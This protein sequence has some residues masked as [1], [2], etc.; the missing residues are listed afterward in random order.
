M[1]ERRVRIVESPAIEERLRAAREFVE[2][3][4]PAAEVLIVGATREAADD[5]AREIAAQG[6]GAT[7]GMHRMSLVQLAVRC[8]TPELAR[9]RRAPITTLGLEALTARVTFEARDAGALPYFGAVARF[10]GFAPALAA[11]VT[12]LRCAA[13]GADR[14]AQ[15][16]SAAARDVADLLR[17]FEAHLEAAGLADRAALFDLGSGAAES[18]EV[19]PLRRLPIVLLDV[20]VEAHVERRFVA[21]LTAISPAVLITVA[22]GDEATR[23]SIAAIFGDPPGDA[24]AHA[25]SETGER[26]AAGDRSGAASD[27]GRRA[28]GDTGLA[29]VRAHLFA[30]VAPPAARA[31]DDV[32]FF[33]APGEG[34]EV[35]EIARLVLDRAREGIPFDRMAILLRAP[36]A[37]ASLLEAALARGGIP[38]FFARGTRRPDPAGRAF[39]ALLQCAGERFSARRFAEY[40][41]LGQVPPLDPGGAP[42]A[43]APAWAVADDEVLGDAQIGPDDLA[44]GAGDDRPDS[45]EAPVVEGTLRAPWKWEAM[46]VESA[47]IGGRDRWARRLAGLAA[48]Y[49]VRVEAARRDDP[50]SPRIQA[51]ERDLANLEHLRRFA[52][53]IVEALAALPASATWGEW[54]PPL[55]RLAPLVLRR[56]E[57]VLTVL[58]ELR[59]LGPVGPVSL[60]EVRDV[61][62]DRLA[63]LDQRPP[64]ARYGSVFVGG[65]EQARGR[66]FDVVFVP[67]L[68]ERI[69]PQK[70]REDPILLDAL[71]ARIGAGLAQQHERGRRE[72]W[73]LRLAASAASRRLYLSYARIDVA[74]GRAR[75]PS[76]YALE[77]QRALTG[78][79][80]PP[81]ALEEAAAAAAGARLAWPAPRDPA[82][83][84]D[85]EEHDL[86]VLDDAL[87]AAA[88][89]AAGRARYL[90]QL[91]PCLARS[92]RARWARW[93]SPKWTPQDGLV[94][95]TE[96]TR[97][98]FAASS[99]RA[100]PYS[101]SALQKFA[102]CP[103]QFYLSAICRLEPREEIAPLDRLDPATRGQ[104]FHRVQAEAMRALVSA[105]LLPLTAEREPRARHIL[106]ETFGRVAEAMREE[107]APAIARV[108]Q[109][110]ID[111]MR[112]DLRVWLERSVLIHQD[113]EP[114]AFELAF[115]LAPQPE[116][117]PRSVTAEAAVGDFRLRGIVDLIERRRETPGA[118]RADGR[119]PG[120]DLRVTDYKTGGNYT[121]WRMVVGGGETLQPVLY[122]LAV[123]AVLGARVVEGRLFYCTRE[124]A[125]GE[126]VVRMDEGARDTGLQVL[127]SVD[128]ALA[129]GFL[130]AAPRPRA[131]RR[132]GACEFCDFR[133][134]CGPD[135]ERRSQ[136]KDRLALAALRWLRDLP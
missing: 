136:R 83:A 17:R 65:I 33:A 75:V 119:S 98:V 69:F 28:A 82:R 115:G 109:T 11:T 31:P 62:L 135:E 26:R 77:V 3:L 118:Q 86:A 32:V 4:G 24:A 78:A 37:Y 127:S 8:A 48:N 97:D 108:W 90:L 35:V 53:P 74:V 66:R 124:G 10:P 20:P 6:G 129:R 13:I 51:L 60:D 134:V 111:S 88:G 122:P 113:W 49:R 42:I 29:R 91:N 105:G 114:V 92:L 15:A 57:R 56:H 84:V 52:L 5:I 70:P 110:E 85:A 93:R 41:S 87:R 36:A 100:R 89:Q 47:V 67:G 30:D 81:R 101:V 116:F 34:R 1:S 22:E 50:E 43:T 132:P 14:I 102:A 120:G 64:P 79:I 99:L 71:R 7:F 58:A 107:L 12:E 59:P 126:R 104:I 80:P 103:Y 123:E 72:R 131:G 46:L 96:G 117:D 18:G 106:D 54:L 45:D 63:A 61:L 121:R 21:A 128:E 130:P 112:V 23:A 73:L 94:R 125:F 16:G 44:A 76:F 2:S 9:R 68:A 39:L 25:A 55:E 27:E 133:S 40:L 19:D 38:A 95:L